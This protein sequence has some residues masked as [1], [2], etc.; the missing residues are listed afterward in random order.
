MITALPDEEVLDLSALAAAG[1]TGA[2]MEALSRITSP[3]LR[4]LAAVEIAYLRL[5]PEAAQDYVTA[6]LPP[7]SA[8]ASRRFLQELTVRLDGLRRQGID[9][10][11]TREDAD[12][13][14]KLTVRLANT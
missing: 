14:I 13:L 4:S 10:R 3:R 9:A 11:L 8:P 12:N 6:V 2:H 1:L 5:S 7:P